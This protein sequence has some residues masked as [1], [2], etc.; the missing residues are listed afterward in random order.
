MVNSRRPA[1]DDMLVGESRCWRC[2]PTVSLVIGLASLA[3][4]V[5]QELF[6][7]VGHILVPEGRPVRGTVHDD[8]LNLDFHFCQPHHPWQKPTAENTNGLIRE[9][10]PKGT[11]FTRV[12]DEEMQDVF[13]KINDRPRKVLGFRTANEVY[14]EML[15]SA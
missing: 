8:S 10:F 5:L 14:R 11:D 7:P 9:F 6:D 13:E 15:H 4:V 3:Q 12:T 1:F 2:P